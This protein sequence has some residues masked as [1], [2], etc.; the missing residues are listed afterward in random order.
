MT[1]CRNDDCT[2]D[3]D[4]G[5]GWDGFC[6]ACADILN[7]D[8]NDENGQC[9]HCGRDNEGFENEPCS[10]DCPQYEQVKGA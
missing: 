7:D 2:Q 8:N 10:D 1:Q 9:R 3:A 6:G 5:E 4:N